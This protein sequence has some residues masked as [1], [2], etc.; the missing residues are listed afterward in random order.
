MVSEE[1]LTFPVSLGPFTMQPVARMGDAI[2]SFYSQFQGMVV[3]PSAE[4]DD[5]S[6][7]GIDPGRLGWGLFEVLFAQFSP[8]HRLTLSDEGKEAALIPKLATYFAWAYPAVLQ[9][10]LPGRASEAEKAFLEFG[11]YVYFDDRSQVVGV[12]CIAPAPLGT[13]GLSFG[14]PQPLP[15]TVAERLTQA[16]RFQEVSL[17]FLTQR[18][19]TH[20]AWIRPQEFGDDVANPNGS[21]AY[22]FAGSRPR[23]F[24]VVNEP[25]FTKDLLSEELDDSEVWI[26]VRIAKPPSI[27]KLAI[28]DRDSLSSLAQAA[29]RCPAFAEVIGSAPGEGSVM[30]YKDSDLETTMNFQDW[31]SH[32]EGADI[33]DPWIFECSV[34]GDK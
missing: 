2:N 12:N 32:T 15:A 8:L 26:C 14:R 9:E 31:L 27:D 18:G 29:A 22:K 23:Y 3:R 6:M 16:G 7:G 19:A 11:G 25:S 21:F 10:G 13:P 33:A 17:E 5:N 24:P 20:F 1:M 28:L 30:I 4:S 34:P